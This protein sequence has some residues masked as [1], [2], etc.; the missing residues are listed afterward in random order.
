MTVRTQ[1]PWWGR[2]LAGA[3]IVAVV[4]G[5]WWWGFDFG[6]LFGGVHRRDI[7]ARVAALEADNAALQAEATMLRTR[8]SQLES[9]AAMARGAQDAIARQTAELSAEN[10]QLKEQAAFLQQLLADTNKE[11]GMSLP[12]LTFERQSDDLW[13]Y[14]VLIV[15]GGAPRDEFAGR[16]QLQ[17]TLQGADPGDAPQILRLPDDQPETAP[18]LK[19]AF[20]YYQRL[21]GTFRVP[22]GT[23]VTALEARA[24]E[25]GSGSPRATRTAQTGLTNP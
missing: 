8:T 25:K 6:Q 2:S 5:M 13:R 23:R 24:F 16:L 9:E 1:V 14:S 20:K 7:E 11:P 17:A 21:E 18:M 12:R 15:R 19:L 22:A 4:V 10:A 3:F